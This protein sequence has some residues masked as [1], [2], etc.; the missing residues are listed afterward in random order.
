MASEPE[1][2]TQKWYRNPAVRNIIFPEYK[3]CW[4][5]EEFTK[6]MFL[7]GKGDN[8][9]SR[10]GMTCQDLHRFDPE[11][12][13]WN[14]MENAGVYQSLISYTGRF[15]VVHENL[16]KWIYPKSDWFRASACNHM[17][18]A[19][20]H[21]ADLIRSITYAIDIDIHNQESALSNAVVQ[22]YKIGTHMKDMYHFEPQFNISGG[23]FHV[24]IPDYLMAQAVDMERLIKDSVAYKIGDLQWVDMAYINS[25]MVDM[26]KNI[27]N[28]VFG[29]DICDS[30]HDID[31][32]LHNNT[33]RV[34]R[35]PYTIHPATGTVTLPLRLKE[36]E[37]VTHEDCN[38][39]A[40]TY[41]NKDKIY[42]LHRLVTGQVPKS[43]V[44]DWSIDHESLPK[45][46]WY[47]VRNLVDMLYHIT[48][49]RFHKYIRG[50]EFE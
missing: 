39:T 18:M 32:Q 6:E 11:Q 2:L 15:P 8:K 19:L 7:L 24:R 22:G 35:T 12:D 21:R 4:G 49:E 25:V 23:G 42:Q 31:L 45:P 1:T 3:R 50:Y 37:T 26:T 29:D 36:L 47:Q 41:S 43:Y 28:A 27:V 10:H 13:V 16:V 5:G 46:V 48:P 14:L 40:L 44:H 9:I 30:D 34:F 38:I 17:F 20:K 33:G